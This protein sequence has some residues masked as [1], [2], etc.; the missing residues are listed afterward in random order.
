MC[1]NTFGLL[2]ASARRWRYL[3][4]LRQLQILEL[5]MQLSEYFRRNRLLRIRMH[6]EYLYSIHKYL[7]SA[8]VFILFFA[9]PIYNTKSYT[10]TPTDQHTSFTTSLYFSI[11]VMIAF[12]QFLGMFFVSFLFFFY[13]ASCLSCS[14]SDYSSS[15]TPLSWVMVQEC[16]L[17]VGSA[18]YGEWAGQ[19]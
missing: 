12:P 16:W 3:M 9:S 11:K 19:D 2:T 1:R 10:L 18:C 7:R 5:K 15:E 13:R 6:F 14:P 17:K 8:I 4:W